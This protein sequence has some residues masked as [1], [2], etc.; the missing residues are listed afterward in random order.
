[1]S[2]G[3][4]IL[5]GILIAIVLTVSAFA[6]IGY[7][8]EPLDPFPRAAER[9]KCPNSSLSVVMYHRKVG[10]FTAQT[11]LP[12]RVIDHDGNVVH[13]EGLGTFSHWNDAEMKVSPEIFCKLG[14]K[15]VT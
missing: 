13:Q 1:M 15:P 6:W 8:F 7:A 9:G 5:T 10:W 12:V 4:K 11:Q 2:T 14:S 3:T